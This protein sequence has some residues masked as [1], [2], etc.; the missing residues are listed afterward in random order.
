MTRILSSVCTGMLLLAGCGPATV[1]SDGPAQA[2]PE[3][4]AEADA[5]SPEARNGTPESIDPD[6]IVW[7]DE[8]FLEGAGIKP[9]KDVMYLPTPPMVV[10]KM[11]ALANIEST[12]V[13]Y[14]L[15]TG[16]GRIAIAAAR[17]T[18]CKAIGY[19]IDPELVAIARENVRK[20][21]LGHL[22][23]IEQQDVLQLD[24]SKADVVLMYLDLGLNVM[25]LPQLKNLKPGARV[26][27]HDWGMDGMI[28]DDVVIKNFQ[29]KKPDF[30]NVH[31]IYM[32]T[33]PLRFT[34][35]WQPSP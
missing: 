8:A 17:Q 24:F 1:D 27:S 34:E 7:A 14:D 11:I 15:G 13:V 25:L 3:A 9:G 22:V 5:P 2:A 35:K 33:A 31:E 16:D 28:E 32:W 10:D 19:E 29:S 12:D 21:G 6:D 23:T 26:V 30:V 20:S 4:T 18:G